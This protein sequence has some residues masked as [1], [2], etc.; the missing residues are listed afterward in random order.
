LRSCRESVVKAQDAP[1]KYS[2]QPW[3]IHGKNAVI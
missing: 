2:S 1:P 3:R